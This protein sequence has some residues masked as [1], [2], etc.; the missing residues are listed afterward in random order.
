MLSFTEGALK[1]IEKRAYETGERG[2]RRGQGGREREGGREGKEAGRQGEAGREGRQGGREGECALLDFKLITETNTDR[3]T[4]TERTRL[5]THLSDS[6]D[7]DAGVSGGGGTD[8][9]GKGAASRTED[10]L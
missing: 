4:Q 3:Q 7:P 9:G 2:K 8:G 5:S 1:M 10:G 6:C